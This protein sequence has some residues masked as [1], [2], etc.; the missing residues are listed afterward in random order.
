MRKLIVCAA[1]ALLW[2]PAAAETAFELGP[3]QRVLAPITYKQ[4][5][6][7]PIVEQGTVAD[8][9]QYLTLA[10]GL[11]SKQVEVSEAKGGAAVNHV[12]VANHSGR[13]LLLLGGEIIL[14]GQQDRILGKDTIIPA[15]E[16]TTVQVFC[17]EHGRWSG[18][19]AF[20][21]TGGIVEGKT[22]AKAKFAGDQG[23]VWQEVAKKT[24][25]LKAETSTGTYRAIATGAAGEA[26]VKPFR[27]HVGA[28]LDKS[29]DAARM[30]GFVAA[31]NG[32][33]TSVQLFANAQLFAAYKARLLDAIY[34]AA[35]DVQPADKVTLPAKP[36]VDRFMSEANAAPAAQAADTP[37][38]TT[39]EN[40]GATVG[41][42]QLKRKDA[43]K[44][45]PVYESY[46]A[47]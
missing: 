19:R 20:T 47:L 4:L 9:T 34:V 7:F 14:G 37:A 41:K 24:A 6:I 27:E 22:R 10:E 18:G 1:V 2:R 13:P 25:A 11:K 43:P 30:V 46:D 16:E 3:G 8:T 38:S 28:A 31:V 40:K 5:A 36:D 29:P 12:T 44:A 23:Q 42:S 15:H 35:A 21:E 39:L 33:V 45:K 32:R 26:A 17:V